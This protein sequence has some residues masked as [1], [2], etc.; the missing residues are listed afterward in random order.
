[1]TEAAGSG[2]R[3]RRLRYRD[4]SEVVRIERASFGTP[5]PAHE[6]AFELAKPAGICLAAVADVDLAGYLVACRQ[7]PLWNLRNVA[8]AQSS[9]RRGVGS[10][11]L[12]ALLE[13]KRLAGSHV[14]LEV[15]ES[16]HGAIALYEQFGFYTAGRRP[17]FYGDDREDA[18]LMWCSLPLG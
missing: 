13:H 1:M 6:F 8:V 17:E 12:R 10:A 11:L 18:L 7:G 2:V 15:R 16:E 5:W 9:R 4:I 3:V 14:V